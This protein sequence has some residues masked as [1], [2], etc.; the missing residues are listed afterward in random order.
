MVSIV[1]LRVHCVGSPC[2]SVLVWV[3]GFPLLSC[4]YCCCEFVKRLTLH[5]PVTLQNMC[6]HACVMCLFACFIACLLVA[7]F[8]S[9]CLLELR[10]KE[11]IV[12]LFVELKYASLAC[13]FFGLLASTLVCVCLAAPLLLCLISSWLSC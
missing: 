1:M 3:G 7:F 9:V 11:V 5:G 12:S 10:A 2:A 4:F 6:A 13:L 8:L